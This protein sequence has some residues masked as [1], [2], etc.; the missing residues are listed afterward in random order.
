MSSKSVPRPTIAAWWQT[1]L[2]PSQRA[3]ARRARRA[4]R[5]AGLEVEHADLLAGVAQR[6]HDVRA[7]EAGAA[8]DEDHAFQATGAA[9]VAS[10]AFSNL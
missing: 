8:G 1:A 3:R 10:H 7:D 2:T 4:R 5:H 9:R 6:P